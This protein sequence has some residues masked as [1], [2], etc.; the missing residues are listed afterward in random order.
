MRWLG[1]VAV[2]RGSG[3]RPSA[4]GVD[5]APTDDSGMDH[6][7]PA[8]SQP[9]RVAGPPPAPPAS[10]SALAGVPLRGSGGTSAGWSE[11]HSPAF[12]FAAQSYLTG[13]PMPAE[14]AALLADPVELGAGS[15]SRQ[16][17]LSVVVE[18]D[19]ASCKQ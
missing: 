6:R 19:V 3:A 11:D 15:S 16:R 4:V 10:G 1:E 13:A 5:T 12:I 8:R 2:A 9:L 18:P 17:H 7:A 14:L